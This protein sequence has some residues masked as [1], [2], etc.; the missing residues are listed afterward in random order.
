ME[1]DLYFMNVALE[2]AENALK[3]GEFPVACVLIANDRV[4]SR[5][6]RTHSAKQERNEL[7]HAEIVAIRKW[8]KVGS[9]EKDAPGGVTAYTTLEPCLMC[10]GALI[11]NGINR[12]VYALEDVMGGAAGINFSEP[13]TAAPVIKGPLAKEA[14]HHLYFDYGEN[15]RGG[16]GRG[17]ALELFLEFF[18]DP[19]M[20]YWEDSL[21]SRHILSQKKK[22]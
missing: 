10:L 13:F 19:A 1:K 15:I 9:P 21:L 20:D 12:I 18:S 4:V 16:V 17:K 11:L 7:D 5:G 6:S 3:A 8:L 2:L 22:S 14:S